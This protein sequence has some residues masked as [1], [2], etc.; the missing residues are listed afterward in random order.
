[1]SRKRLIIA[2]ILICLTAVPAVQAGYTDSIAQKF[3]RGVGNVLYSPLEI[4]FQVS[5][6]I[7]TEDYVYAVPKGLLKGL[8]YTV[9]RLVVGAYEILTF[10]IPQNQI[11][12]NFNQD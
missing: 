3:S 12:P 10:P 5:N 7:A 4:P 8:F 2:T 9:G 1:M 11:I 6:E